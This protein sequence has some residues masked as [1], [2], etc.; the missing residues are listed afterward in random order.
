[1]YIQGLTKQLDLEKEHLISK[2]KDI[3]SDYDDLK[4][5]EEY[6]KFEALLKVFEFDS[7]T[8]DLIINQ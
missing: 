5:T 8:I 1:M 6:Q 3:L 4:N 7:I 2:I